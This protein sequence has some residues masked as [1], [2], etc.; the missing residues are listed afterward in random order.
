MFMMLADIVFWGTLALGFI[1]LILATIL[2]FL[3]LREEERIEKSEEEAKKV[4]EEE[5]EKR[6]ERIE[7]SED[8]LKVYN[9][10]KEKKEILQS[11]LSKLTGFA[12]SKITEIVKSLEEKGLIEREKVGRTY[13]IRPKE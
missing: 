13:K 3:E 9:I 6:E 7:L 12:K 10:I 4:H 5:K 2:L 8:E 11:E 1:S